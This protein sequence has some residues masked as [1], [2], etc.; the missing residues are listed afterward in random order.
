MDENEKKALKQGYINFVYHFERLWNERE[1]RLD[2]QFNSA[3]EAV[4]VAKEENERRLEALNQLRKDVEKD[5]VEFVK[6]GVFYAK[7]DEVEKLDKRVTIIETRQVTWT[8]AIG[9]FF[10][11]LQLILRFWK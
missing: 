5:R 2:H 7:M 10:V 11:A 4:V 3:K 8:V 1:K 9:A 6:V